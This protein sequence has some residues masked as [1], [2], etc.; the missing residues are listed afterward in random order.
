MVFSDDSRSSL[1][2]VL[3]VDGL[4]FSSASFVCFCAHVYPP[5][6]EVGGFVFRDYGS[7]VPLSGGFGVWDIEDGMS[8][9]FSV[10]RMRSLRAVDVCWAPSNRIF[11]GACMEFADALLGVCFALWMTCR[12]T[13][14]S[15]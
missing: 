6:V 13:R 1:L 5:H 2:L 11:C 12:G 14:G 9:S 8:I 4:G 15:V 7:C 3:F 10:D